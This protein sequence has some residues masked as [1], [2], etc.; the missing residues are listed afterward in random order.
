MCIRL[1]EDVCLSG[2]VMGS[3]ISR[4]RSVIGQAEFNEELLLS[5]TQMD[6]G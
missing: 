3:D 4:T 6:I 5:D 1:N 2:H